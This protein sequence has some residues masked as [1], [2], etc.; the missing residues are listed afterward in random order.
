MKFKASRVNNMALNIDKISST[1]EHDF[2]SVI[3][4]IKLMKHQYDDKNNLNKLEEIK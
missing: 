4:T 3:D 2:P 1:L